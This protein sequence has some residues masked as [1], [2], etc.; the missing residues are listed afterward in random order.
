MTAGERAVAG[1]GSLLGGPR[2]S[3]LRYKRKGISA[4][5]KVLSSCLLDW[6]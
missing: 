6:C 3:S 1:K 4:H 2:S 5:F